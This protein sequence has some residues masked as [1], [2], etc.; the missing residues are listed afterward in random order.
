MLLP[1]IAA[2]LAAV[3]GRLRGGSLESLAGTPFRWPL[4]LWA[5]LVLQITFDV[6][7]PDW[8]GSTG[9]LIVILATNVLVAG[10]LAV[11]WH[12]PGMVLAAVGTLL[13]VLVIA[14]NGAMPVS[15]PA[16]ENAGIRFR[17]MGIKHE[18]LDAGTRLPWLADVIPVPGL[19]VLISVG[20]VV[21]AMGLAWLVYRRTLAGRAAASG[22]PASG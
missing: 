21:L 19:G 10:F 3:A 16:A 20:D 13:N 2:V 18:I 9:G 11:N 22:S 1:L 17:E 12:L 4:L 6:W 15:L 7:D 8:L 5:G 14:A